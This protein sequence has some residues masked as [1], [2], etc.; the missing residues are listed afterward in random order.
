MYQRL[1][2]AE[3]QKVSVP[4]SNI[5]EL[6]QSVSHTC[7]HMAHHF[8]VRSFKFGVLAQ[9]YIKLSTCMKFTHPAV[10]GVTV[11]N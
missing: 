5:S 11:M 2:L 10:D 6:P 3:P 8:A 7:I 9:M 4:S 1:S